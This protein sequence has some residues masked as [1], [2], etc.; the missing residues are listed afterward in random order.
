MGGGRDFTHPTKLALGSIQPPLRQ[1][2][3]LFPRDKEAA[4]LRWPSALSRHEVL[5][6]P[7]CAF[8]DTVLGEIYLHQYIMHKSAQLLFIVRRY[9]YI[10]EGWNFNFG[11]TPLDWIQELLE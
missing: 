1:V 8:H 6:L 4:T 10:Y 3:G 5:L 2:A 7:L 9:I 11:N